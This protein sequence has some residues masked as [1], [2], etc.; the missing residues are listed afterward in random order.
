MPWLPAACRRSCFG[1]AL[2]ASIMVDS[3][4]ERF[5]D[6]PASHV[7]RG[8]DQDQRHTLVPA[9]PVWIDFDSRQHRQY[10]LVRSRRA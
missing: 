5:T 10:A 3:D 4:G 7:D 8:H 9:I 2:A 6:E 1:R